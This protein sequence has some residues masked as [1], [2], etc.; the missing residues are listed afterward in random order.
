MQTSARAFLRRRPQCIHW[1]PLSS[2]RATELWSPCG[3]PLGPQLAPFPPINWVP[4]LYLQELSRETWRQ[5]V[6]S[7]LTQLTNVIMPTTGLA[8]TAACLK[9]TALEAKDAFAVRPAEHAWLS[10]PLWSICTEHNFTGPKVTK[11]AKE[12]KA[13]HG[14][15]SQVGTA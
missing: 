15:P 7:W 14:H 10:Q 11:A 8:A 5:C 12:S 13:M 2:A 1:V 4:G 3:I 6:H 9:G